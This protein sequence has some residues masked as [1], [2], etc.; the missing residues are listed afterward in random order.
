MPL[1]KSGSSGAFKRNVSTLMHDVGN[2]PHVQSRAQALAIAY[3]NQRRNRADGGQVNS[4]PV[5][6]VMS[7]LAAGSG[8]TG[9]GANPASSAMGPSP[10]TPQTSP[11]S[12]GVSSGVA[13]PQA[14]TMASMPAP[15]VPG[16]G[17][18]VSMPQG[19]GV[20]PASSDQ[21]VML[22]PPVN[23]IPETV[24]GM[25]PQT[26]MM[27]RYNRGGA[28][29]RAAGGFNMAKAP[30]LDSSWQ[31]RQEARSMMHTGPILSTVPGRTD[32]HRARVPSG[33]YVLPAQH[34][35]SMGQGNSV[36]GLSLANSLFGGGGPYGSGG[37]RMAHGPGAPRPRMPRQGRFAAG[38][39]PAAKEDHIPVDVM[40]SGG[41]YVIEP[42]VVRAI[43]K[44]SL[45]NGHTIL[46][47]WVM[48]TRK[49][50]IQTQRK[51]PP[52]AK[53]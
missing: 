23:P 2:S 37:M 22:P 53:K 19:Q 34:I 26:G 4:D 28:T 51:L 18:T 36:A 20:L 9:V 13:P 31:T 39:R 41:E 48:A 33:S 38:G 46:D 40:L 42:A 47:A 5:R 3:S 12:P 14:N 44:G 1:E 25:P 43:G 45:K 7:A 10:F 30:H 11:Y 52:P 15:V 21:R 17:T 6:A 8:G 27:Q 16:A 24:A 32:N 49:R 29:N 35:A 50:E